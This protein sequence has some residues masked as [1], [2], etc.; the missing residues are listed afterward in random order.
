MRTRGGSDLCNTTVKDI[1]VVGYP[2]SGCTWVTRLVA[3]LVGCP[4]AGFWKSDKN[5]IAVEGKERVSEFAVYKSHHT[6]AELG[7]DPLHSER[8][9]IYVVRDPR[10]IAISGAH[11]FHFPRYPAVERVFGLLPK[12][13][14]LY[15]HTLYPLF[16]PE[17]YRIMRMTDAVL[18][19]APELN[20]TLR[21]SWKAHREDYQRPDVFD[22]RYEEMLEAPEQN[23]RAILDYL[24]IERTAEQ[25]QQAVER[26]SFATKKAE[27]LRR[28]ERGRAKFLR[29][30]RSGQWRDKLPAQAKQMFESAGI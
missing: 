16:V 2:K 30:G 9:V 11:H 26:Q 10:D 15:R 13:A 19:G 7:V 3:E 21:L 27:F 4:V 12:G 6:F 17:S 8:R 1:I 22:V 29:V 28:G 24:K 25:I 23:C 5:E 14:K 20:Q 18:H